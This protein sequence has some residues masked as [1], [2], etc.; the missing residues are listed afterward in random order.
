MID[1]ENKTQS[2]DADLVVSALLGMVAGMVLTIWIMLVL[3]EI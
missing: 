1:F 3:V 2:Q